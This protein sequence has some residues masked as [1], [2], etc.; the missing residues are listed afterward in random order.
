MDKYG[1]VTG[2]LRDF[3]NIHHRLK[4]SVHHATSHEASSILA[5]FIVP[6]LYIAF[7]LVQGEIICI[8]Q[9]YL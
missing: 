7:G 8:L 6:S 5:F 1:L 9:E 2:R 3:R 4:C